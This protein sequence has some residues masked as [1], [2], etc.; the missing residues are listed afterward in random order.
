MTEM[1]QIQKEQL[2][3]Q[4]RKTNPR[5]S[6]ILKNH[7]AVRDKREKAALE[8]LTVDLDFA[9]LV[10]FGLRFVNRS[11]W[12]ARSALGEGTKILRKL[13][14]SSSAVTVVPDCRVEVRWLVIDNTL[15]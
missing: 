2:S 7:K 14:K 1:M 10:I 3:I 4:F 8:L 9:V 15:G 5:G 12:R 13:P 6:Q 11:Y